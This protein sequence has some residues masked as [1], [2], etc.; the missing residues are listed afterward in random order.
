[1]TWKTIEQ[2]HIAS[3]SEWDVFAHG[4]CVCCRVLQQGSPMKTITMSAPRIPDGEK[5]GG[6]LYHKLSKQ[7]V[8]VPRANK[9]G[10]CG[11]STCIK[12]N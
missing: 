2:A 10:A 6:M 9:L 3:P 4:R 8:L 12:C 1:M 11:L 7:N 5:G